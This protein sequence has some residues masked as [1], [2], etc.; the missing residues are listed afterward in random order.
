MTSRYATAQSL[1]APRLR[2]LPLPEKQALRSCLP[3]LTSASDIRELVQYL[4]RKPDGV[5]A[6]EEL[7]RSRKR[8]FEERRLSAYRNLGIIREAEGLVT[9]SP[10]GCEL[11]NRLEPEIQ[12]FRQMLKRM[13][14]YSAVLNWMHERSLEVVTATDLQMF[15]RSCGEDFNEVHEPETIR[16]A[17]LSFFN[18]CE[19]AALGTMTLGKRGHVTRLHVDHEELRRFVESGN[20]SQ[21]YPPDHRHIVID[22]ASVPPD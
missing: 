5:V 22:Q 17:T 20:T 11:A 16:G 12:G 19:A 21:S 10:L 7:D 13:P 3:V 14:A 2:V 4:K 9:L 15:W 8:L 1:P 18:L 6:A